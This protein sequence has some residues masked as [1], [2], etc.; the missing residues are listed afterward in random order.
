MSKISLSLLSLVVFGLNSAWAQLENVTYTEQAKVL[1]DGSILKKSVS[2]E[3]C[4]DSGALSVQKIAAGAGYVEFIFNRYGTVP[5][6]TVVGLGAYNGGENYNDAKYNL[7]FNNGNASAYLG[8]TWKCDTPVASGQVFRISVA[9]NSVI[10]TKNGEQFCKYDDTIAYPLHFDVMFATSWTNIQNARIYNTP[11]SQAASVKATISV[12]AG[13]SFTPSETRTKVSINISG[14]TPMTVNL[15][16]DG[17][18]PFYPWGAPTEISGDHKIYSMDWCITLPCFSNVYGKH[19]LYADYIMPDGSTGRVAQDVTVLEPAIVDNTVTGRGLINFNGSSTPNNGSYPPSPYVGKGGYYN[20][21]AFGTKILRVTDGNDGAYPGCFHGYSY[22]HT[23]NLDNTKI[24]IICN[25]RP[26]VYGFDPVNFRLTGTITDAAPAGSFSSVDG[27]D[28]GNDPT[29]PNRIYFYNQKQILYND[30][31]SGN[32]PVVV[33]DFT[34]I[35]GSGQKLCQVT[36]SINDDTFAFH[37]VAVNGSCS[38]PNTN[39]KGYVVWR[40]SQ[41]KFYVNTCHTWMGS[42]CDVNE[43]HIN[44]TGDY[45][46]LSTDLHQNGVI[47]GIMNIYDLNSMKLLY[48][49]S[50]DKP[51]GHYDLAND[52]LVGVDGSYDNALHVRNL[53]DPKVFSAIGF[54][55]G[56]SQSLHVSMNADNEKWVLVS[57]YGMGDYAD[58]ACGGPAKWSSDGVADYRQIFCPFQNEI[59]QLA[60]DGTGSVRRIAHHMSDPNFDTAYWGMPRANISRDG[61]FVIYSSAW[62]GRIDVYIAQITPAP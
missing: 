18:A 50:V 27:F 15:S 55:G 56:W 31:G 9:N 38:R 48:L 26:K 10:F 7:R 5:G 60:T 2:C 59:W 35:L 52:K 37:R 62:G 25:G 29:K 61:K 39:G 47:G 49:N 4:Y 13:T 36:R 44:K 57:N 12:A 14:G 33:R 45:M 54:K 23:F 22:W 17:F 30:V 1:F 34:D 16:R 3:A 43:V 11:A 46:S 21:P 20:D 28:W 51:E 8:E 53:A 6:F 58:I 32:A 41:D 24:L 40:R 19:T 42:Y